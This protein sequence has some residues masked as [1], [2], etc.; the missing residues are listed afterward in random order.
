MLLSRALPPQFLL[1]AW[2]V[3]Q[4]ALAFQQRAHKSDSA[5]EKPQSRAAPNAFSLFEELF[6]EEDK[7]RPKSSDKKADKLPSFGWKGLKAAVPDVAR[8]DRNRASRSILLRQ[9][10]EFVPQQSP[11]SQRVEGSGGMQRTKASVLV[12]NCA[13]NSLEES[14]FFRVNPRG[15][16]IE[17]WTSGIIKVIPGRDNHTLRPLDHYF[18]LFSSD[19]SARAYLDNTFRLH[20]LAKANSRWGSSGVVGL[21][22]P[23]GFLKEGEDLEK[24]IKGFSLVPAYTRLA[25]RLIDKSYKPAMVRLLSDGGPAAIASSKSKAENMVLFHTDVNYI[26]QFDLKKAI[27]DD[28]RRRNLHWKL[29]GNE[30]DILTLK[31][32]IEAEGAFGDPDAG[33]DTKP[34]RRAGRYVISFRDRH[35][36][37]RFVREWHRRAFPSHRPHRPGDEPPPIVNVEILW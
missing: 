18:I 26:S 20:R 24:I 13:M 34:F 35:E 33:I 12:L 31:S 30:N 7:A 19:A 15:E 32:D 1:P 10:D 28:G 8:N 17:G 9:D 2:N 22:L 16:H 5:T 4:L 23:P 3:Q 25:L 6:P 36:A 11:E 14:D 27:M 29:A 37:R 21:P